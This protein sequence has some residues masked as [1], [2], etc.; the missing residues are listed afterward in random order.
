MV[1]ERDAPGE[2]GP[3]AAST[4]VRPPSAVRYNGAGTLRYQQSIEGTHVGSAGDGEA[5]RGG[6]KVHGTDRL[7]RLRQRAPVP[8]TIADCQ[9][10]AGAKWPSRASHR[11]SP[12]R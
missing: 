5:R 11:Q 7:A 3:A 9:H 12:P 10:C 8:A 6:H 4:Q 1:Y 2:R